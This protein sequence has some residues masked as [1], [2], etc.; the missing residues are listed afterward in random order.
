M[1]QLTRMLFGVVTVA[2]ALFPLLAEARLAAN[3]SQT[4]VRDDL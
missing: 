2:A 1:K 3:D 4:L